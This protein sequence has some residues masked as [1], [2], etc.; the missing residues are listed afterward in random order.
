MNHFFKYDL[1]WSEGTDPL[2]IELQFI[3][4]GG[5]LTV[6]GKSYGAGMFQHLMNARALI[7]PDRYCHEWLELMYKEFCR[8]DIS[9]CLGSASCGKTSTA[10]EYVL[11]R[12]WANPQKTL[13][14]LSTI[15]L[16]KLETGVFGEVKML[17]QMGKK[18]YPWLAGN[19][20]QYKHAITTD[21]I[22][23]GVR[24]MRRGIKGVPCFIGGKKWVGLGKLA[25]VKQENIILLADELQFM[26]EVFI[27]SWPNLFSNGHVKIIG[28]GNPRHDPD[29]QLGQAAEPENGWGSIPEPTETTVWA[30]RFMGGRCVNLVGTDS[31]N[32]R[33]ARQGKPEIY[34]GLI[35]TAYAKRIAHDW[36]QDSPE[37]YTQVLGVMKFNLAS[38][39]VITRQLCR[40][41]FAADHAVWAGAPRTKV[42]GLDPS[43][44]G[45]DACIEVIVEF[46]EMQDGLIGVEVVAV[47]KIQLSAK[48]DKSIEDQIADE[49]AGDLER[50]DIPVRN[51]FYDPY[52]KGTLGFAFARRFGRD[53]P[54]PVDS[55]GRPTERPVRQDLMVEEKDGRRRPKKCSEHYGKFVSEAWFSVRYCIEANQ[56]RGLPDD[57]MME[58]CGRKY[59]TIPGNRIDVES[60]DKLKDRV[61][62][63][64]NKMDALAVAIEG[65]RQRGFVIGILGPEGSSSDNDAFF[66]EEAR[67]HKEAI[68][69]RLLEHV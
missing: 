35:G 67:R 8:N 52:G 33:L 48:P 38:D 59:A 65:C 53:C 68:R 41:H 23:D 58:G 37:Y 16:D 22:E 2:A 31:P 1:P 21:N 62:K 19:L 4:S 61:G 50:H 56:L 42:L 13:V 49:V 34:Q 60:K 12:Y 44:G 17:W 15:D 57:V 3:K 14:I 9:I 20:L 11:L 29:D 55:G 25:G 6:K 63:S 51:A 32:F 5:Y 10:S 64:P 28:S 46:G 40:D 24:D 18:R 7:W 43:Y 30:T 66:E 26:A 54:I 69:S 45:G 36:R 27:P 47:K 39:R